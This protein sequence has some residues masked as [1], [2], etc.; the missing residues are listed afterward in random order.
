[1]K[2]K[3]RKARPGET[4]RFISKLNKFIKK[5]GG[6]SDAIDAYIESELDNGTSPEE[7]ISALV[8]FKIP[9]EKIEDTVY[10]MYEEHI[11]IIIY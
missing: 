2:V 10:E 6:E 4:P 8:E 1:M 9:R 11:F 3:I 7:V 5:A